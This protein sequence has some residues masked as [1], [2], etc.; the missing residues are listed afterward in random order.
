MG[1][2]GIRYIIISHQNVICSGQTTD[3]ACP[4]PFSRQN[5]NESP[6]ISE[7]YK[8][9]QQHQRRQSVPIRAAFK[10]MVTTSSYNIMVHRIDVDP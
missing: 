2:D 6:D 3:T 7:N 8:S 10:M 5:T 9:Q 4:H 1:Y